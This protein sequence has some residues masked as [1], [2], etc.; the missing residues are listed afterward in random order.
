MKRCGVQGR[1]AEIRTGI[2]LKRSTETNN[3]TRRRTQKYKLS[4]N[5]DPL[6]D[7]GY[8]LYDGDGQDLKEESD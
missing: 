1:V 7:E 3:T 6:P 5:Y 2:F 4:N 8:E